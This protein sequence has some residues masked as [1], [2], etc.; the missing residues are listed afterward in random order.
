MTKRCLLLRRRRSQTMALMAGR[1]GR[2][3]SCPR[4]LLRSLGGE[5]HAAASP[6]GRTDRRCGCCWSCCWRRHPRFR[7]RRPRGGE[8]WLCWDP[9]GASRTSSPREGSQSFSSARIYFLLLRLGLYLLDGCRTLVCE[10]CLA[11]AVVGLPV[12][13]GKRPEPEEEERDTEA[14]INHVERKGTLLKVSLPD[15][16]LQ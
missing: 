10:V 5:G 13:D 9:P 1:R 4:S 11:L 8:R 12:S 3:R 14:K 2:R 7:R 15:G 16:F 6:A